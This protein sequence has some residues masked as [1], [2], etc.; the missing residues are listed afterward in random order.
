MRAAA[1]ASASRLFKELCSAITESS[2]NS[3][4][5]LRRVK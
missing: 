4:S 3:M 5:Q 1:A 2:Q